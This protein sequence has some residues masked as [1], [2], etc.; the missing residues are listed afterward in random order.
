[1]SDEGPEQAG[2]EPGSGGWRRDDSAR[3]ALSRLVQ[4]AGVY[5]DLKVF[6]DGE[7]VGGVRHGARSVFPVEPGLR[8]VYVRMDWCSSKPLEVVARP[9][10]VIE[11]ECGWRMSPWLVFQMLFQP[12]GL[13]F[14]R[15]RS[16]QSSSAELPR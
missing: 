14:V 12:R 11:L 16:P 4:P 1:M 10:E 6:I 5:R 9:G 7:R 13:L 2:G 3:I 8:S 15:H